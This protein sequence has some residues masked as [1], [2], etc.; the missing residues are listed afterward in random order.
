MKKLIYTLLLGI[1]CAAASAGDTI[2]VY[3]NFNWDE[4]E[5]KSYAVYYR[6]AYYD[7]N[8]VWQVRDYYLNGTIQ[9]EGAHKSKKSNKKSGLFTYYYPDGTKQSQGLYKNDLKEGEWKQWHENG[10]QKSLG[11]YAGSLGTGEW[12]YWYDSGVLRAKGNFDS[13]KKHGTWSYWHKNGNLKTEESIEKN[14]INAIIRYHPNGQLKQKGEKRYGL[15][16]GKWTYY[17][18]S[19]EKFMEGEYVRDKRQGEWIR[20]FPEGHM[21]LHYE[22]D[23]LQNKKLGGILKW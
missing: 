20:Y 6:K 17:N 22:N 23:I 18:E 3:Y 5:D 2:T 21:K 12:K 15:K 19:G 16:H 1:I 7:Q 13:G 14:Q 4:V 11:S 9:M 8:K 10:Q